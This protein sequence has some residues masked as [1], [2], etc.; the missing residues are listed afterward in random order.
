M[1]N[2]FFGL[3][4]TVLLWSNNSISQT[5]KISNSS[6]NFAVFIATKT[7]PTS[8][9]FL[10]KDLNYSKFYEIKSY[11]IKSTELSYSFDKIEIKG[12]VFIVKTVYDENKN[13]KTVSVSSSDA[14]KLN[15]ILQ[16]VINQD[17]VARLAGC[18]KYSYGGSLLDCFLALFDIWN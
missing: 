9:N 1:K 2:I 11:A 15:S 16:N 17:S 7:I 3:I 18:S 14:V 5:L 12:V 8:D 10:L 6:E 4:A 13:I